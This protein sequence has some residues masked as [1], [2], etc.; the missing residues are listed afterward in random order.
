MYEPILVL[1][2]AHSAANT[3]RCTEIQNETQ[4][5]A[6]MAPYP[7]AVRILPGL[8]SIPHAIQCSA[9]LPIGKNDR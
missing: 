7:I 4:R 8:S 5:A 6:T 3:I 9:R 2:Y 1:C